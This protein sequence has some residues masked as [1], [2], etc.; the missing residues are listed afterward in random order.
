MGTPTPP[1]GAA[2]PPYS[3]AISQSSPQDVSSEG[4]SYKIMKKEDYSPS[5]DGN[6]DLSTQTQPLLNDDVELA[7]EWEAEAPKD[8]S[9]K[10]KRIKK[11][12]LLLIAIGILLALVIPLSV[13]PTHR[14][15]SIDNTCHQ[16]KIANIAPVATTT[17]TRQWGHD[18]CS[19]PHGLLI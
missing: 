5:D 6:E 14:Q 3:V 18:T 9:C 11:A 4:K 15:V 1:E 7:R 10:R 17:S 8:P 16:D 12:I 2:P 19:L 13:K